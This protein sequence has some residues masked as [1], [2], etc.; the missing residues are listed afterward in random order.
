MLGLGGEPA[1]VRVELIE[2]GL[3]PGDDVT[4][5][6]LGVLEELL[7]KMGIAA[8]VVS[9]DP[10]EAED[11]DETATSLI[12]DIRGE[13]LGI[14]I[15][16][17]GQTLACLQFMVRLIVGHQTKTWAPITVDVEGAAGQRFGGRF[18][19]LVLEAPVEQPADRAG[20]GAI[21]PI[22]DILDGN[23]GDDPIAVRL[24]FP[25]GASVGPIWLSWT[26]QWC[27]SLMLIRWVK[28]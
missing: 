14:L 5:V 1:K 7:D 11:E 6:A 15:G 22:H 16:R 4:D 13:D 18:I 19:A 10:A 23:T 20:F 27:N 25:A 8:S 2:P 28:V 12:F 26:G 24:R 17:R 3:G 21:A 9:P